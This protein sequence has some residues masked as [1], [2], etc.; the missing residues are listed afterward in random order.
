MRPF[1]S[2][3]RGHPLRRRCTFPSGA[4]MTF[5]MRE[6][7]K[8]KQAMR[9]RLSSLPLVEKLRLLGKLRERSLAI[10]ASLA[11]RQHREDPAGH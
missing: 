9:R 8:S 7:V 1:Y 4:G 11:R 5:E 2:D 10:L 6:I 3:E